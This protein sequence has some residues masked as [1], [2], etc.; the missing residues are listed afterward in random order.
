MRHAFPGL[1]PQRR[2]DVYD[3]VDAHSRLRNRIAHH[4]PVHQLD[5]ARHHEDVLRLAGY[6]DADVR[7]WIASVSR[8]GDVLS[9]RP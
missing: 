4:E 9:S 1:Q 8:V 5:L 6:V 2:A 3:L 7:A